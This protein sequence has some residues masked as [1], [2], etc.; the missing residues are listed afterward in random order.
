MLACS[1]N[2]GILSLVVFTP[3]IIPA[4]LILIGIV[5]MIANNRSETKRADKRHF[6][7][8]KQQAYAGVRK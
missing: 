1:G 7:R 8:L 3:F 4:M 2:F 6:N 5:V